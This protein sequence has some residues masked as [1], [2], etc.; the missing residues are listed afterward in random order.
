MTGNEFVFVFLRRV[1]ALRKAGDFRL[2]PLVVTAGLLV[3]LAWSFVP[4]QTA[5]AGGPSITVDRTDDPAVTDAGS[6]AADLFRLAKR[7]QPAG[8]TL[9]ANANPGTTI[10]IPAGTY[11][12]TISGGTT[13]SDGQCEDA[14]VGDLDISGNDTTIIGAGAASTIIEQTSSSDRVICVD[15]FLAGDFNFTIQD[16]TITGGRETHGVG[17]G[18]MISGDQGDVTTVTDVVFSNNQASGAGSPVGGGLANGAGALTITGSTFD[19]NQSA[20][21][22]GGL[23]YSNNNDGGSDTLS[24]TDSTFTNNVS[25]DGNGGGLIT[26]QAS[27]AYTVTGNTF[28][29]NKA[30]G[31]AA[32]GGGIY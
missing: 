18:G 7:L 29:G 30:E 19:A 12:L 10:N 16:L 22:G 20:G 17:G 28:T 26:T 21:S 23:Y 9:V 5:Q 6:G 32:R 15:Q 4:V 3:G 13:E 2:L 31:A 25:T 8:A 24:L 14:T 1:A 11:Q 27:A